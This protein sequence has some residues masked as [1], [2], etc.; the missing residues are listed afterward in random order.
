MP[1]VF[2]LMSLVF[3]VGCTGG[4]PHRTSKDRPTLTIGAASDLMPVFTEIRED[5]KTEDSVEIVFSFGSSGVLTKQVEEGAPFDMLATASASYIQRV[6]A[7]GLS[8]H[9]TEM[10]FARGRL[11]LWSR[12]DSEPRIA[13]LNDLIL[14]QVKRIAVANPEHAPY[15][16]AAQEVLRS[17]SI[18]DAIREKLV[19]SENVGQAFQFAHTGNAD[20]AF[21]SSSLVPPSDGRTIS[22]DPR[23]HSPINQSICIL[24]RTQLGASARA[25]VNFL[26]SPA[27][28]TVLEKFGFQPLTQSIP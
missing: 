27:G 24:R 5:L 2:L 7:A 18:W 17:I 19:Y 4:W 9:G 28:K 13:S 22:V 11:V 16:R 21:I 6:K 23:Y 8:V 3:V 1:S 15:G 10:V 12:S 14:P 26:G 20:A 25:F